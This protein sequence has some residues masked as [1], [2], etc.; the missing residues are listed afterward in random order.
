MKYFLSGLLVILIAGITLFSYTHRLFVKKSIFS[1][2]NNYNTYLFSNNSEIL[3]PKFVYTKLSDAPIDLLFTLLWSE[4]RDFFG[5][6][7][8]NLKGF[9]RAII[10]NLTKGTTYGGSTITQQVIK[11]IYL[12]QKRLYPERF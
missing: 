9:T 7:G 12:S 11:N 2:N 4:D 6:P 1:F 5:H 8:F 3:P 10:T